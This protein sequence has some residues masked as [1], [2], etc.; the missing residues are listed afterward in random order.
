MS[1]PLIAYPTR[2]ELVDSVALLQDKLA[3]RTKEKQG[4]FATELMQQAAEDLLTVFFADLFEALKA[5][6]PRLSYREGSA[7][8]RDIR[9]KLLHY[10]GWASPFFGNDRL[11]PA[12]AHYFSL[13]RDLHLDSG[14]QPH[15][16]V[17][18]SAELRAR[19]DAILPS[20]LAG[21]CQ[22]MTE[23]V[24]VMNG[25]ILEALNTLLVQPKDL[26]KFNFIVN[27]TLNGVISLMT[28]LTTRSLEKVAADMPAEHQPIL[29]RHLARFLVQPAAL[30]AA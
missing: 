13:F 6:E 23:A 15:I 19:A 27:K 30:Q 14:P 16:T 22:D 3:Q 11:P 9:D 8:V 2:R 5:A 7:V 4:P 25:V 26:M 18:I 21:E 28:S 20:L 29:G 10:L 1:V 17:T 24:A 12:V